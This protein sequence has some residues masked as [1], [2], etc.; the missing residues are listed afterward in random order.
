[1]KNTKEYTSRYVAYSTINGNEPDKQMEID[2][3]EYPGGKMCGFTLWIQK[4][5][6]IWKAEKK[7][8]FDY[9][10]CD[11]DQ[12][13][14]DEWLK[15]YKGKAKDS[16]TYF[17]ITKNFQGGCSVWYAIL[18][19]GFELT[20]SNWNNQFEDWGESTDGGHSY[21]YSIKA[22]TVESLP[23]TIHKKLTFSKNYI[24]PIVLPTE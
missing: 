12:I 14:F 2:T 1:M 10:P 4:A 24:T 18:K 11:K 21:G 17:K 20:K 16:D 9:P 19:S 5:W 22:E 8:P 23:T 13:E 3:I 7:L 15:F 6:R